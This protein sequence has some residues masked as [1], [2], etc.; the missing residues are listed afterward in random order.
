MLQAG[1][2]TACIL[3]DG[4]RTTNR[5]TDRTTDRTTYIWC[6][7][8]P[9]TH[10]LASWRAATGHS[11]SLLTFKVA[12]AVVHIPLAQALVSLL[13]SGAVVVVATGPVL[14]NPACSGGHT[15]GSHSADQADGVQYM[16]SAD[17][18]QQT[19]RSAAASSHQQQPSK[20]TRGPR[21]A[22]EQLLATLTCQQAVPW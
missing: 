6:L 2:P 15:V 21:A 7:S 10:R 19:G 22:A 17:L 20:A 18:I 4:H 11:R 3:Q 12:G 16:I 14:G 13:A 8:I 9:L 1:L 5:T